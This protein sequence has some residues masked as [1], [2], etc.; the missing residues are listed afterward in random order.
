MDITG[1]WRLR[2]V[3]R[4]NEDFE[5]RWVDVE[6]A[7]NDETL[8]DS[9]KRM[10]QSVI[11]IT[12][13]GMIIM[14]MPLPENVSQDQIDEAVASGEITLCDNGMFIYEKHPWKEENGCFYFN[15]GIKGEILGE[16]IDPWEKLIIEDDSL[17]MLVYRFV[18]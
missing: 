8:D 1:K 13:E 14:M 15:S 16:E 4:F 12:P 10:L 17:T 11:D 3:L 6:E 9:D 7:M 5:K 18:R 2:S